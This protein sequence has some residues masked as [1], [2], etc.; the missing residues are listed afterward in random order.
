MP[1]AAG[2]RGYRIGP[3]VITSAMPKYTPFKIVA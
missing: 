2:D 1:A 3:R